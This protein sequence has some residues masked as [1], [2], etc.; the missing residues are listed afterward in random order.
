MAINSTNRLARYSTLEYILL[1][2]LRDLLDQPVPDQ[3]WLV[4]ILDALLDTLPREFDLEEEDGYL[5]EVLENYPAW[6]PEVDELQSEHA[7]LFAMLKQL[8]AK[9]AAQSSFAA[10]AQDVRDGLREWILTLVA[11]NRNENRL[12]QTAMNL[13]VGCGD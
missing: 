9:I 2:D 13:D 8:R 3:A 1:G 7:M 5:T 4:A 6:S 12:L 11:H 10:L